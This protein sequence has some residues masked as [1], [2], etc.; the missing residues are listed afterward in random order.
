MP[1]LQ[2]G[3]LGKEIREIGK[4]GTTKNTR[5]IGGEKVTLGGGQLMK[6]REARAKKRAG[7][8]IRE[9]GGGEKKNIIKG[10]FLSREAKQKD[11]NVL[12]KKGQNIGCKSRTESGEKGKDQEG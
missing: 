9:K 1:A 6:G 7:S 11:Q 4:G 10:R 2:R 5:E 12:E 8:G 3:V